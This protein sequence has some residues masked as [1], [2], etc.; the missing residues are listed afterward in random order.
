MSLLTRYLQLNDNV[1]TQ[2]FTFVV[3]KAVT[4]DFHRDVISKNFSYAW[5]KWA[6]T[7]TREDKVRVLIV[8]D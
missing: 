6:V 4:R 5:H 1:D 3:T 2:I 8:M 7:F